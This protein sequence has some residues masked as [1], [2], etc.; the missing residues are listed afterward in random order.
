MSINNNEKH[1]FYMVHCHLLLFSR[2]VLVIKAEAIDYYLLGARI[3]TSLYAQNNGQWD[4]SA[5]V[6]ETIQ[7]KLEIKTA[8]FIYLGRVY[9]YS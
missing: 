2:R 5:V 9:H 1:G 3:T 4:S 6:V 8:M 7:F